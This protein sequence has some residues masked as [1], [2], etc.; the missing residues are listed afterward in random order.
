ML[1]S[2]NQEQKLILKAKKD[3]EAF[4]S[5]YNFYFPKIFRFTAYRVG[6]L[7]NTEDIVADIFEKAFKNLNKFQWQKNATF[8]SWLFRIA[9]NTIID[10]YKKKKTIIDLNDLPEIKSHEILASD[11]VKRQELFRQLQKLVSTLPPRQAEIVTL[12]FFGERRNKEIAAI[13]QISEKTVASNL[14]RGLRRLHEK[15]KEV[16]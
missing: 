9:R 14:C 6:G 11:K 16:Q 7:E 12:R 3:P 10:S 2:R 13:L 15:Y 4:A 8:A 1:F 5:L